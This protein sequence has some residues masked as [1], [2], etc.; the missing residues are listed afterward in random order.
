MTTRA[1]RSAVDLV[2]ALLLVVATLVYLGTLPRNLN[3]S[4]EAVHL[5]EAKRLL[6]G[7][8][9]YRDI[10]E[11]ITPGWMYLMAA[12]FWLFGTDI[13]TARLGMAVLHAG[14]AVLIGLTC[15]RLHIRPTLAWATAIA[16]LALC[17][18][19]WPIA[20]QHWL[21][22]LLC[23]AALHVLLSDRV[24]TYR[25]AVAGVLLGCLISVQQQRGVIMAAGVAAWCC[26][27][28]WLERR[29]AGVAP[30]QGMGTRL[31]HVGAGVLSVVGPVLLTMM[32]LAG[33]APVWRA[34]VVHPII[35]YGGQTHCPW[36]YVSILTLE[37][38]RFTS[39]TLLAWLPVGLVP[40]VA[41]LGLGIARRH[42]YAALRPL[43]LL[44]VWCAFSILSIAYFPDF[45][46]IAF[47]A[48]FF[49][50]VVAENGEWLLRALPV[51]RGAQRGLEIVA[52]AAIVVVCAQQLRRNAAILQQSFP[53]AR[54]TA[55]GRVAMQT[56]RDAALYE[57]IT[58]L[59]DRAPTRDLYS[60]PIVAHWYLLANATN[61]TRY[62]FFL[63][64]Y[65]AP[66][67][68]REVLDV[69]AAAR[70]PYIV[71][72]PPASIKDDPV[73]AYIA[74][75]YEPLPED[76]PP[77]YRVYRRKGGS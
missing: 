61:P 31:L 16:Y 20:S 72:L 26:V 39:P 10:F 8:V 12:L 32:A 68:V 24:G 60:Y 77:G 14:T 54:Q 45:I 50:I 18:A 35:N 25:F 49:L 36:G 40:T 2:W 47:I 27:D 70:L 64:S 7:Q 56:E 69:L 58:T 17:Q 67:Q 29:H 74:R 71:S 43:A 30:A 59:L 28:A 6:A 33:F 4:D 51:P 75:E 63:A 11:I 37:Y 76:V 41:R 21:S 55:F 73:F 9:M 66:D 53:V 57:Q 1:R 3:P 15:R 46:H 34:L 44:T 5:Y 19:A 38:A 48:P 22:T 65:N 13:V 42:S 23:V 62:G 52:V